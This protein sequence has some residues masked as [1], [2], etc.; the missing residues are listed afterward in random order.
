MDEAQRGREAKAILDNQLVR[1]AFSR[2]ESDW[3]Q[4]WRNSDPADVDTREDAYRMLRT[5]TQFRRYFSICVSDGR[6][7]EADEARAKDRGA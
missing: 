2:L 6:V 7:A 3:T 5:I 1:D 4:V